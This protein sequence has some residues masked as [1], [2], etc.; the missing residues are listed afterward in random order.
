MYAGLG[1]DEVTRDICVE[2]VYS[3]PCARSSSRP[4]RCSFSHFRPLQRPLDHPRASEG[5]VTRDRLPRGSRMLLHRVVRG[6][7]KGPPAFVSR[8]VFD[9]P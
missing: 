8:L 1:E 9:D 5:E 6:S 2:G 4:A 3:V 7:A